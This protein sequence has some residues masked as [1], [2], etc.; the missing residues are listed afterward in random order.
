MANNKWTTGASPAGAAD[1][2]AAAAAVREM[3]TAIA[4]RYY[5]LNHLLEEQGRHMLLV[6]VGRWPRR[7]FE[8][9][10][11]VDLLRYDRQASRTQRSVGAASADVATERVVA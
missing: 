8:L 1:E 5:L 6:N 10:G 11:L 7:V 3:F 2:R 4:P 9:L